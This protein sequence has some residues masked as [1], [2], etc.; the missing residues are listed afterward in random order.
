MIDGSQSIVDGS[1]LL[2]TSGKDFEYN[3]NIILDFIIVLAKTIGISENGAR[4]A[5][6]VFSNEAKLEIKFSDHKDYDSFKKAV[7]AIKHPDMG[8]NTLEGFKVAL[9]EMFEHW[10]FRPL[11]FILT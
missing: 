5:V 9:S 6:V 2:T 1:R 7:L 10:Q 8:T 3:W 11:C 4:M